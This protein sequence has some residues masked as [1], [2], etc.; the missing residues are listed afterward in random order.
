MLE[1]EA[2]I[3]GG[4]IF[5]EQFADLPQV[6]RPMR[7]DELHE[8]LE[9]IRPESVPRSPPKTAEP[10]GCGSALGEAEERK[11]TGTPQKPGGPPPPVRINGRRLVRLQA[12][13]RSHERPGLVP[14]RTGPAPVG[15]Q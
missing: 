1:A 5:R 15:A 8:R 3:D 2:N 13:G 10:S 12:D 4:G 6:F 9:P 11:R 14:K 7:F